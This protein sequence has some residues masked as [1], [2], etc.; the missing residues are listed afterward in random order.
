MSRARIAFSSPLPLALLLL[1][2]GCATKGDYPSLAPR[3]VEQLPFEEPIK[4]DPPVAPDP[5]LRGRAAALLADARAGDGSF[6][7]AYAR[8]L[9]LARGAGAAGSD[10][11]VLAQEA[12]SRVEAARM[13]TTRALAALDLLVAEQSDD[14]VNDALWADIQDMRQAAQ[15]LAGEQTRRLDS[16]KASVARP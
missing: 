4:V 1:V 16:L 3:A 14:A 8:A 13:G 11:W 15:S 12:I 7:A 10:S 2:A 9:P 5:D 6:E